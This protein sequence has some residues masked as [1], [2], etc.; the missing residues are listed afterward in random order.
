MT[1]SPVK[2]S[3]LIHNERVGVRE[4]HVQAF[5]MLERNLGC[6]VVTVSKELQAE[7]WQAF[8]RSAH[9]PSL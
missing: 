5:E 4:R 8:P 2:I 3:T 6:R 1:A 7:V 9:A